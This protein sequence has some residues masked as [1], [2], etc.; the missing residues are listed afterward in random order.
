MSGAIGVDNVHDPV[1]LK[2]DRETGVAS[3]S[4]GV[5]VK[6]TSRLRVERV[7]GYSEVLTGS[8][9]SGFRDKGDAFI[10]KGNALFLFLPDQTERLVKSGLSGRRISYEQLADKTYYSDTVSVFGVI[11]NSVASDWPT[12]SYIQDTNRSFVGCPVPAK[13]AVLNGRMYIS[14]AHNRKLLIWSERGQFGLFNLAKSLR[15]FESDILMI[16]AVPSG[17]FVSTRDRTV[18]LSITSPHN[19]QL[20]PVSSS[21]AV[22]WSDRPERVDGAKFGL[23]GTGYRLWRGDTGA[24]IG[25]PTGQLINMTEENFKAP[26]GC[27]GGMGASVFIEPYFIHTIGL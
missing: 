2:Y 9:H 1:D 14:P 15:K 17:L 11:E 25:S 4:A 7:N 21:P 8:Y 16:V 5:N 10:G 18:F 23:E 12:H 22:E 6:V 3:L 20:I 24:C 26:D 27:A 13:M 19:V